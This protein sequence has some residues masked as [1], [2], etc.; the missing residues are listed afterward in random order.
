MVPG[1]LSPEQEAAVQK[2]AQ[3]NALLNFGLQALAGSQAVGYKPGLAQIIGQ[4]GQSGLQAYQGTFD[5]QLQNMLR[6]Q[7]MAE[8]QRKRQAEVARQEQLARLAE[9]A[10]EGQRELI[11][12]F[13]E[14]YAESQFREREGTYRPLSSDEVFQMIGYRPKEGEAFQLSP[15]GSVE[16]I[17]RPQRGPLVQNILG[18]ENKYAEAFAKGLAE[19][20][21]KLRSLAQSAPST[22]QTVQETRNLLEQ[23]KVFTGAFA[24]KRLALAAA[25]KALGL[26]GKNTEELIANT[27]RLASNRAKA[28]LDNVKSSGLGAG[29][30]FTDKDR[31]FLE[32][33]VQGNIEFTAESLKRQLEIEEK[34]ARATVKKWNSRL[35]D[36]PKNVAEMGGL[37]PVEINVMVDY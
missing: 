4:A 21:L 22:L 15:K 23:G 11:S 34:V 30:G 24:N 17:V 6:Q 35:K 20:D 26:A 37:K 2:Q 7:Q 14:Q 32:R 28:T 27:E 5:Q 25:G 1:L 29:Q 18:G 9:S 10:P 13:P 12:L 31:E 16:P 19:D 8:A 33:A 36:I 3:Q